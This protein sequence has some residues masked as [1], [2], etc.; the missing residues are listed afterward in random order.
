[1]SPDGFLDRN[2]LESVDAP[3][4]RARDP[5]PWKGFEGLL[6]DGAYDELQRTLPGVELFQQVVGKRRRYG[7]ESH[8]RYVLDYRSGLDVSSAWHRFVA[9]L[10]Q[11]PYRDKVA[12]LLGRDDFFVTAHWH[13]T[14]RG[15]SV[16]PHCDATWKLGSHIFYFN[17]AAEWRPQWGGA[18]L[19]LDDGGGLSYST[20]PQFEDF[21]ASESVPPIG[22]R[23]LLFL[24]TDHSWHGVAPLACPEG[25]FRKVFIIE[26]RLDRLRERFR[27]RTGI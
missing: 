27:A 16:S 10:M 4:I 12:E 15:C 26:Y 21:C 14:P 5:Y 3:A 11:G 20:A 6:T 25:M 2:E 19:V 17:D 13:Y 18:T 1:L 24:R 9:E 7:Q 23:S 22:N 8:D